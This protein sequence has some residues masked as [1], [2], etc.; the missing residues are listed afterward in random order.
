MYVCPNPQ[1]RPV[2]S[3]LKNIL[4]YNP[5]HQ[6]LQLALYRGRPS[7]ARTLL[8]QCEDVNATGGH[9]GNLIQAAAFGGHEAMVRWLIDLG[10]DVHLR[11]RYG[12]PLRAA[13]LGGHNAVVRLLLDRG[14]RTDEAEDNALQAA[15][16]NGHFATLKLLVSRSEEA[17]NWSICYMSAL[18]AASFKAHLEIV[19]FLLQNRP[20]ASGMGC[21]NRALEAA[22][23]SGQGSVI[24]ML[25]E[26]VP[27]LRS[28]GDTFSFQCSV[29]GTLDLLP[30]KP[31][32]TP[33]PESPSSIKGGG[34]DVACI[35]SCDTMKDPSDWDS[36]KNRADMQ[37]N[38][39]IPGTQIPTGQEYLL[40]IAA[41]QGNKRMVEHLMACGFELNETGNVN[42][43]LSHQ[44]TALE[45]AASKSEL[46][47]IELLLRRGAIL[48]KA[49]DFAV[50][51]GQLDVVRLLLAYR[52]ETEIDCFI[53]PVELQGQY[54]RVVDPADPVAHHGRF[55][56]TLPTP[57][58][59]MSN[60]SLLAIA[61]EWGHD[62][63]VS[64]LLRHKAKSRH[65]GI[66]LSML[67]AARNGFEG[68]IR[69]FIEYGRA[70]DGSVDS[71][72][73]SDF[74]LEQSFREA[75]ANGHLHIVKAL[76]GKSSFHEHSQYIFIAMCEAR[77]HGQ[78]GILV[79]LR[80]LAPPLDSHRLIGIELAAMA[81]TRPD[82]SSITP[83]LE[84]LYDRLSS[85]RVDPQLCTIFKVKALRDALKTGQYE[86]AR[87]LLERDKSYRILE[88]ETDI[89]H[90]AICT[91]WI[92]DFSDG[93]DSDYRDSLTHRDLLDLFIKHGASN[94][95]FDSLRN[96][97]L[98]Y[99]CSNPIPGVFDTL[100]ES[101]A[102]LWTE[103]ALR[104]SDSLESPVSCLEVGDANKFNL[105]KVAL[106][107]R[108]EN[109]KIGT[110]TN[111]ARSSRKGRSIVYS[112]WEKIILFLLDLGMP[113]DPSDPIL[114]S[115]F[116]V[117]CL[118][119]SLECV[120]RLAKG[121]VNS[122]AA[123]HCPKKY[124]LLGTALHAAVIGGRLKVLQYLLE[125]GVDVNQKAVSLDLF[126]GGG[127]IDE[128]AT[129]TAVRATDTDS[130]RQDRW[131]VLKTLLELCDGMD[132][133][134]TALH[135]A[136]RKEK[137]EIVD[138]LLHRCTTFLD[139]PLCQNVEIV[140]LFVDH[141]I[142]VRLPLEKMMS[143][144]EE[145]IKEY[146]VPLLELLIAQSGLL[147]PNPLSHCRTWNY[148]FDQ[149]LN[150]IRFLLERYN[151]DI[152]ATFRS[153]RSVLDVEYDTNMLL[154]ACLNPTEKTIEFLLERG[155][156]PDGPGLAD[157]V[158]AALFY[159]GRSKFF[160]SDPTIPKVRL[161]LN[162][163]AEIN[164]SKKT[165]IEAEKHP[166]TLQ[167]PLIRAIEKWNFLMVE[168]LVSNG[169]DVNATSGPETPLHLARREGHG[170]I[171]EYLLIHGAIDRYE[172]G[173]MGRRVLDRPG[174]TP[175]TTESLRG[176]N[177]LRF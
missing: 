78:N 30:P 104:L 148:I 140:K 139:I 6:A 163:G 76:L 14:A 170:E 109:E 129:Q 154:K 21:E 173:E 158:L 128:T 71:E 91:M 82:Q 28:I 31:Q 176:H 105:L 66:G 49:L 56:T 96:T 24:N 123:G 177:K 101:K 160:H 74:L 119:G 61:V 38:I 32:A 147:L 84:P 164:G 17:C 40:R 157:S 146:N 156:D 152:N 153:R 75:S 67:V 159:P 115:F 53:D 98:F 165:P 36:L 108:I 106:Q 155:A 166:R 141:G 72:I 127:L 87:F 35:Q 63:I 2:S 114:V 172:K 69:K 120:Q 85:E 42:E 47:I 117:A 44:P 22:V 90:F 150:M 27:H 97:P 18:E 136:I 41:G 43:N 20:W 79:D 125:I 45:V 33:C 149:Q 46:D 132:D 19:Q 3:E 143:W 55:S 16:L 171:A 59:D 167:P 10:A 94:E 81:S 130:W 26:E 134:T 51:D 93:R 92:N 121:R 70:K 29:L 89:L 8:A 131:D 118:R 58:R 110:L 62:E 133:Y 4:A 57:R 23:V 15:A 137:V 52:P 77:I 168:F 60:R 9:F 100:I 37:E 68:T 73:I 113:F 151:C 25:I 86:A 112:E 99:A 83:Y 11:G 39:A 175:V 80:A 50:R 161:L 103:H 124:F 88:T 116:H 5:V 162:H 7:V 95:S 126:R 174:L 65:P 54:P 12:S 144:H 135:A 48:G 169:A 111:I 107:S 138:L 1:I 122:H 13:S 102:N 64:V 142:T 145:A 34:A